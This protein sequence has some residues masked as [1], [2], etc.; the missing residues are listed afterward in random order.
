MKR[1]I[2]TT[3]L[4]AALGL[5]TANA[6]DDLTLVVG[7]YTEQSTSD[8]IYAYRFNQQTGQAT[9]LGSAEAGN[10]S[11]LAIDKKAARIYA[12]SEYNDGRQGCYAFA[13]NSRSGAM[14]LLGRQQCGAG[15]YDKA[16]SV[17]V[18]QSNSNKGAD[19]CNVMICNGHVV[20]SNYTGGDISVFPIAQGGALQPEQQ[21]VNMHTGSV[22]TPSHIHCCRIT[23]DRR[24]MLAS[25]LGND[26]LWRFE[27]NLNGGGA[28][29]SLF[30]GAPAVVYKAEHGAGPRHFIFN[31]KGNRVYLINELNGTLVVLSY[32]NGT[33][34]E[35]Q[36]VQASPTRTTG[37][38]DIHLSPDG[39][40][41]Y[42]S[43][44]L[45]DDGVS[46]FSVD[47]RSGL[48]TKVGYQ[49]TGAHPRNF[50]ITP[51]GKF[52]LVACRDTNTIEVYRRDAKTGLLAD[53]KQDIKLGKPVCLQFVK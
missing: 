31:R 44:R 19:P 26:C 3:A 49:R 25:D 7:T 52:L 1:H 46:I 17:S 16:L 9:M 38:A 35:L 39:K 41:L 36:R 13:F 20:T 37:S 47:K 29:A 48:L 4:F 53:T 22:G 5:A 45:T 10:P 2:L 32:D 6:G 40:F 24:Y 14:R 12:V 50:N 51:N 33:L 8:G 28:D 42:A 30:G 43:H 23:P 11:F 21:C 27:I 18:N 34:K 15:E